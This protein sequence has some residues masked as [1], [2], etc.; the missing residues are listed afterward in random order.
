MLPR[1]LAPS[2]AAEQAPFGAWAKDLENAFKA[3]SVR[4]PGTS[5]FGACQLLG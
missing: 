3:L 5:P 1:E 4:D 2:G